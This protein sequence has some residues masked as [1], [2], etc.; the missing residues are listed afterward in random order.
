MHLYVLML[1]GANGP[2][3]FMKPWM[4]VALGWEIVLCSIRSSDSFRLQIA[5]RIGQL[6]TSCLRGSIESTMSSVWWPRRAISVRLWTWVLGSR[7]RC[8][9]L[10]GSWSWLTIL[11]VTLRER[12]RSISYRHLFFEKLQD[13]VNWKRNVDSS[14]FFK[15]MFSTN[16][17]S[18]M[19]QLVED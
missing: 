7:S 13:K 14:S 12:H 15:Y 11:L 5:V 1:H 4:V 6:S 2:P 10:D 9:D 17:I 18:T 3:D 8:S 16:Y 19:E